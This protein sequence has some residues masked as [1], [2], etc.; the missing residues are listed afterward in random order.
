[1]ETDKKVIFEADAKAESFGLRAIVR[2]P[3]TSL[4][5]THIPY[6]SSSK[7]NI[8]RRQNYSVFLALRLVMFVTL[9]YFTLSSRFL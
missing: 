6:I 1:M 8:Q 9:L 4:N 5:N 3:V 7:R 2:G